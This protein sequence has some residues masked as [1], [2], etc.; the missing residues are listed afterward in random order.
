[1]EIVDMQIDLI[2]LIKRL[3]RE[4]IAAH[5][6]RRTVERHQ[7]DNTT[8]HGDV[9]VS[10]YISD[11][12]S[13]LTGTAGGHGV[14][15]R[16]RDVHPRGRQREHH[17]LDP[18]TIVSGPTAI[19]HAS[20]TDAQPSVILTIF[21]DMWEAASL[22]QELDHYTFPLN[23]AG[24]RSQAFVARLDAHLM[25]VHGHNWRDTICPPAHSKNV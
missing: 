18:G 2:E 15:S 24:Q 1:M 3:A 6:S 21:A 25:T 12:G 17:G 10:P 8:A 7:P 22:V 20:T 16:S 4:E 14:H 11:G 19:R 13:G 5:E 23:E 9:P